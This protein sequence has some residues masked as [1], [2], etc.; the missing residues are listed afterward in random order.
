MVTIV[1]FWDAYGRVLDAARVSSQQEAE[2]YYQKYGSSQVDRVSFCTEF[3]AWVR[4]LP[5][6]GK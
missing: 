6:Q 4:E 2:E 5:V 3:T 1:V